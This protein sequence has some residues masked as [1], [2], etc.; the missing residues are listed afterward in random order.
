MRTI[1]YGLR[2]LEIFARNPIIALSLVTGGAMIGM[3][4]QDKIKAA[5]H[6]PPTYYMNELKPRR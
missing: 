5:L 3:I 1:Y 2:I 4:A 6:L